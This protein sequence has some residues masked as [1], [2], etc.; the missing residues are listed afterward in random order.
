M[1]GA[2]TAG[3]LL[4]LGLLTL[5]LRRRKYRLPPGPRGLPIVG[6]I[7]DVPQSFEWL[8]YQKW[9]RVFSTSWNFTD[10]IVQTDVSVH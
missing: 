3:L 5:S 10:H 2:L 1:A 7:R 8:T 6:N 9:G 4:F